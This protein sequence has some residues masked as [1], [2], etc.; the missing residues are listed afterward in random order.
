MLEDFLANSPHA[1][2]IENGEPIFDFATAR[3]S[4]SG[5]G[6]CVLHLWSEERNAV[7]RVL[8]AELKA[9]ALRLNVLRFGQS[10]P[11]LLEICANRDQRSPSALRALRARYRQTLERV[12]LREFPGYGSRLRQQPCRPRAFLQSGLHPRTAAHGPVSLCRSGRQCR[13][14]S[15]LHRCRP[16]LRHPL[17]R[18]PARTLAGRTHVEGLKLFLPAGRGE[19]VRERMAHLSRDA[20][21]WQLYE[22]DERAETCE[23]VDCADSGNIE[24]R[25]VRA[26]DAAAAR[27]RFAASIARMRSCVPDC[28]TY[29]ESATEIVFRLHGLEF[30]RARLSPV[31]GSFRNAGNNYLRRLACRV[32]PRRRERATFRDLVTRLAARR[33]A[34][35]E[36]SDPLF[37][38][39]PERWLE[40]LII[41]DVRAID[42]RLDPRFVYSQVPAFASTDRAM[43]DVLTCTLDGRLAILELKADED[44]HLPLQGLDYWARVR[45]HQ[46]NG[47]FVRNG[48]FAGRELSRMS[49]TAASLSRRSSVAHPSGHR[50]AASLPL[51]AHRVDRVPDRRA[52]ARRRACGQPQTP[53]NKGNR[54][55]TRIARIG[56]GAE[57]E[58]LLASSEDLKHAE[59]TDA[60]LAPSTTYTT[61][62]VTVFLE[63]VYREAMIVAL[64][65]RG[66]PSRSARST[67]EVR[68]RGEIV[69]LF[70]TDLVVD[71]SVIVELKC[72]R[73]IDSNHEAQLLNYLKATQYEVGLLLNFGTRPHFRRMV[74]ETAKKTAALSIPRSKARGQESLSKGFRSKTKYPRHPRDPRLLFVL[75]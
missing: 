53:T 7:R 35:G 61:N 47:G 63:S 14:I 74:L 36:H 60:S 16:H 20:A 17:V 41:R 12:L 44:I 42:E 75:K 2:A 6:K 55:F 40:S 38:L 49:A 26:V 28:E 67:V 51:A 46:Q 27:E 39:C 50:H 56:L 65:Q 52:L 70:R 4:V 25:L 1:I 11:S 69:G 73:T 57:M 59:L 43:I 29:V 62:S 58:S 8:D 23:P 18:S 9:Q 68:F 30:A 32:H 48:Y 10:Q 45:W 31:A 72:A 13:R 3:Y 24:T 22:F 33:H 5:E 37:R 19:M 21:K 71:N 54:G 64:R 34:H 15:A 66:L